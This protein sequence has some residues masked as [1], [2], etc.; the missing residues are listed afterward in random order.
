M[1]EH[2]SRRPASSVPDIPLWHTVWACIPCACRAILSDSCAWLREAYFYSSGYSLFPA[3]YPT[4]VSCR[5]CSKDSD[6]GWAHILPGYAP[7]G[8]GEGDENAAWGFSMFRRTSF[9]SHKSLYGRLCTS[10]LLLL[11]HISANISLPV[12]KNDIL[13]LYCSW[14]D[15]SFGLMLVWSLTFYH[16]WV[17]F[18]I[19]SLLL[20]YCTIT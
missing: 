1:W 5:L 17:V 19:L 20:I 8:G 16:F 3:A 7:L 18:S 15:N 4:N 13:M 9:S 11:H 2:I 12:D 14:I 6:A 10:H